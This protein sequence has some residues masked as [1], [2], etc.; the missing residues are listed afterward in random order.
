[1]KRS[2]FFFSLV[3]AVVFSLMAG[4]VLA[5]DSFINGIDA[6]FPPFAYVDKSGT[7][8]GFDVE[9]VN[10]IAKEMGFKVTHQPMDWD[11]IIPNLVAK[12]IDFIASGMTAT[13]ERAKVVNFTDTYWDVA[14]V[15]LVGKDSKLTVDD[16]LKGGKK[17]GVQRGT[18]EATWLEEHAGKD[19]ANYTLVYYDS[20]PLSV[21]D[22]VNGRVDACCMDDAPARDAEKNKSVKILGEFGMK[23]EHFA[24]AVRK[25][26]TKLLETLNAGLKKLKASP[27]WQELIDKYKP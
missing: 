3:V 13:D 5:E 15:M 6:N 25:E 14:Q 19:G 26:D 20:A 17:I 16:V 22:M 24:Y 10:W 21:E 1:M 8:A 23:A 9:A 4:P 7:P 12:K 11:G 27:K 2:A 18:T